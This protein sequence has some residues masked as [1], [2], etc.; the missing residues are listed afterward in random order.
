MALSAR[1]TTPYRRF[2]EITT[3]RIFSPRSLKGFMSWL[4]PAATPE[5]SAASLGSF[6]G[7]GGGPRSMSVPGRPHVRKRPLSDAWVAPPAASV[8]RISA[9]IGAEGMDMVMSARN[10]ANG[11]R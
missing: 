9:G 5:G 1:Q 10:V 11:I 6:P 3:R 2:W 4:Q 8:T 7:S